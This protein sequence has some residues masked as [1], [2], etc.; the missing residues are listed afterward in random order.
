MSQ[1]RATTKERSSSTNRQPALIAAA[2]TCSSVARKCLACLQ[3]FDAPS[4]VFS[5]TFR[6]PTTVPLQ[7]LNLLNSSFVRLRAKALANRVAAAAGSDVDERIRYAFLLVAGRLPTASE[8]AAARNF[9]AEQP[10]QY[11]GQPNAEEL[12]WSDFCQT[13]LASNAFLYVE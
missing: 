7:S 11:R 1:R 4:I 13:L 2:F 6:T 5:C 3:V 12:A 10:R 9:I 8:L